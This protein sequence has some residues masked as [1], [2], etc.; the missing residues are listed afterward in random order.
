MIHSWKV[1]FAVTIIYGTG[2]TQSSKTLHVKS[3]TICSNMDE[4]R[5]NP[6]K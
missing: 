5:D 6:T 4:P 2:N 1:K 3:K